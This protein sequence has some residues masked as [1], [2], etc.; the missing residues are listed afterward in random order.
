MAKRTESAETVEQLPV[1]EHERVFVLFREE[2]RIERELVGLRRV[3]RESLESGDGMSA[4]GAN[5][6]I[7]AYEQMREF[8]RNTISANYSALYPKFSD[9]I[10]A[11]YRRVNDE[12]Y[13]IGEYA[14]DDP[15]FTVPELA[16]LY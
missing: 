1:Q 2:R 11:S 10:S 3:L 13:K 15:R 4:V 12:L 8:V 16:H 5:A 9:E 14:G 6:R 7:K